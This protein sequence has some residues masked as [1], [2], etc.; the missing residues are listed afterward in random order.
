ME[1]SAGASFGGG[2]GGF[3]GRGRVAIYENPGFPNPGFRNPW[4]NF[5]LGRSKSKIYYLNNQRFQ[6]GVGGQRGLAQGRPSHTIDSELFSAP[7]FLSPLMRRRA[8]KSGVQFLLLY[9]G[10]CWS[11]T[12]SRQPLFV[13]TS[14][15]SASSCASP[16]GVPLAVLLQRPPSVALLLSAAPRSRVLCRIKGHAAGHNKESGSTL[17]EQMEIP[18]F[19]NLWNNCWNN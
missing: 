6:K 7:F 14:D 10:H 8:H 9:F 19:R 17:P 13:E 4:L 18:P 3:W 11:P 2:D 16:K 1:R 5:F 15:Q 12:P